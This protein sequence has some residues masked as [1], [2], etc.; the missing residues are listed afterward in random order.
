MKRQIFISH[1]TTF[2]FSLFLLL[3]KLEYSVLWNHIFFIQIFHLHSDPYLD[4]KYFYKSF[5]AETR[6]VIGKD[7]KKR[8]FVASWPKKANLIFKKSEKG[9]FFSI[10]LPARFQQPTKV[11]RKIQKESFC[12]VETGIHSKRFEVWDGYQFVKDNSMSVECTIEKVDTIIE[13]CCESI[14]VASSYSNSISMQSQRH[15][16]G[17][18]KTVGK[19]NGQLVYKQLNRKATDVNYVFS[20]HNKQELIQW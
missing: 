9:N 15:K 6:W 17:V 20:W 8:E 13:G 1:S 5:F 16:M 7:Y 11:K 10:F 4:G 19:M 2:A 14:R 18:Y 12:P 3:F